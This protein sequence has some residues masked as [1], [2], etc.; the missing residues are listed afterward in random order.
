MSYFRVVPAKLF[1]Y[2]Y[3]LNEIKEKYLGENTTA[4]VEFSLPRDVATPRRER[5]RI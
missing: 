2:N 4:T 1:H 3:Y 5:R